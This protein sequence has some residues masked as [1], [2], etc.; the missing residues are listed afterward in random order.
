MKLCFGQINTSYLNAGI[1]KVRN[2]I[3]RKYALLW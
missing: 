1:N 2:Q 3:R